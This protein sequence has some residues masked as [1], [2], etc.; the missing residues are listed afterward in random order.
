MLRAAVDRLADAG[1]KVEEVRPPVDPQH[2]VDLFLHLVS[3][4]T[5]RQQHGVRRA[6]LA[7]SHYAWLQADR[8][9]AAM[10]A[11]WADVVR[12]LRRAAAPGAVHDR[13]P[14][15]PGRQL[16]ARVSS[17]WTARRGRT[18][19][20]CGGPGMFGVLGLPVAVPPVGRTAD[21]LPV[22][23]QV[24][25]PYLRDRDAVRTAGLIAEVAGG[26]DVPPG[27]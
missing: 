25:T 19:R 9:R 8:E 20:S 18:S 14:A 22:G 1:A 3:A 16:R 23:V 10:Q 27:F 24:V 21:G 2:Q 11:A 12:G 26:Y 4:A 5:V 15:P 13:V 7:G 6:R 17:S